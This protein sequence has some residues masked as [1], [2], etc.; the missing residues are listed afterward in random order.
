V[1]RKQRVTRPAPKGMISVK[2]GG[3]EQ[4][5]KKRAGEI[6]ANSRQHRRHAKKSRKGRP[7]G[8]K[9]K[10][11]FQ[12]KRRVK[13]QVPESQEKKENSLSANERERRRVRTEGVAGSLQR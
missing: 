6:S 13:N 5:E 1:E 11:R 4:E 12:N 10:S 2:K 8:D 7:Q 3:E 9:K